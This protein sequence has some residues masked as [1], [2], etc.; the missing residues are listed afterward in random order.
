MERLT[1]RASEEQQRCVAGALA[2]AGATR[3]DRVA[4]L[5]PRRAAAI[6]AILGALRTGVIPIVLN[7]G[8][9]PHERDALLADA[10]PTLAFDGD[11]GLDRLLAGAPTELA[12]A[13][14]GRPM[15]YTSGTT[16][17]PKGVWS[18]VLDERGADAL[19]AEEREIWGF[20]PDDVHLVCS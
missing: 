19:L 15:Q 9:L 5:L 7:S 1:A 2:A 8:L 4:M 20:A 17:K 14:L 13:P 12:P 18:G 10:D 3:G 6:S 16:G 11:D